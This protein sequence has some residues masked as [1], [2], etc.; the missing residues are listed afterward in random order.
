MAEFYRDKIV[1]IMMGWNGITKGSA[2][3]HA[4][5]DLYNTQKPLPRSYKVTYSD[6]WCATT[7]SAAFI[8]AGYEDICPLECG[9]PDMVDKAKKM[10]IWVEADNY[11]PK[12]ADIVMYDWQDSGAGDNTGNPD[13]V[14]IVV[15]VTGKSF[16]VM[17]GNKLVNG[18]SCVSPRNMQ[19]NGRYIRGFITPRYTGNV[20]PAPDTSNPDDYYCRAVLGDYKINTEE[21]NIRKLPGTENKIVGSVKRDA[22]VTCDG[23][24]RWHNT[25][26]W[27]H[28]KTAS[29][30]EGYISCGQ[31][32]KY[33]VGA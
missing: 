33:L 5:I 1:K 3:H 27:L 21:I 25:A 14:G 23:Y 29:G 18:V 9:C 13:H 8:K 11:I 17:E 16:V 28:I 22:V 31:K 30:K 24:C 6:A 26:L 15:E 7:V 4:I 10:G 2:G 20:A 12:L 19:V 32:G